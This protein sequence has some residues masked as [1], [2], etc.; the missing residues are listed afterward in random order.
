[1]DMQKLIRDNK[2]KAKWNDDLKRRE[3][4]QVEIDYYN[5]IQADYMNTHYSYIFENQNKLDLMQR[6]SQ[7]LNLT[8]QIIDQ[9]AVAFKSGVDVELYKSSETDKSE[10][11]KAK[12][13]ELKDILNAC[14]FEANLKTADRLAL[15]NHYC[16]IS[17]VWDSETKAIRLDI[18]P[19]SI[20]FVEQDENSPRNIKAFYYQINIT[21]NSPTIADNIT[22]YQ[23]WT[24]ETSDIVSVDSYGNSR[25]IESVPNPYKQIPVVAFMPELPLFGYFPEKRNMLVKW[26]TTINKELT[27]YE[28][29]HTIQNH[30]LLTTINAE[31]MGN[32][33]VGQ[34]SFLDIQSRNGSTNADAKYLTPGI[35]LEKL[36]NTIKA[37]AEFY[38]NSMGISA[39]LY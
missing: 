39:Y 17:A 26:N 5:N 33:K 11:T 29:T 13:E 4:A 20:C 16:A 9:L 10:T 37:K 15:L 27:D 31:S 36:L 19:A 6:Y 18:I 23:R 24:N 32:L 22:L 14:M 38:A 30:A 1:M 12:E 25:L 35:D 3:I 28:A 21:E 8:E 7:F 34:N 2:K